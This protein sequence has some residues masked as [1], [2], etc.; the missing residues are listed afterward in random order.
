MSKSELNVATIDHDGIK[1]SL[2]EFFKT[3]NFGDFNYEGSAINTIMDLLTRNDT[4]YAFFANMVANESFLDTAQVR[5][6]V[7]SHSQK[8]SYTPKTTTATRIICDIEIV[9]SSV[10]NVEFSIIMPAGTTFYSSV[11]RQSYFFTNMVPYTMFLDEFSGSYKVSDVELYQGQRVVNRF[12]HTNAKKHIVLNPR[13]DSSTIQMNLIQ[14]VETQDILPYTEANSLDDLGK[15]ER[16]WFRGENTQGLLTFEFGR[17]VFGVEPPDNAVIELTYISTETEHA[18]NVSSLNPSSTI[19][20]FSNILVNVTSAGF[21]GSEIDD[22]ETIRFLAP[23]FYQMQDRA[24]ND[25]DYIPLLKR[26]FPFITSGISWGGEENDPKVWGTVFLSL[27]TQDGL[28]ITNG[29]KDQMIKYIKSR[30]VGSITPEIVDPDIF[31][32][33]LNIQFAYDSR[34][35]TST[36]S[37]LTSKIIDVV[38]KYNDDLLEFNSYYN[39]SELISQL[40]DVGGLESV[41]IF[42][43]ITKILNVFRFPNPIYI[44]NFG[45]VLKE[46]T[47]LIENFII[48][49]SASNHKIYDREGLI[50]SSYL[51][52]ERLIETEIGVIEYNTGKVE[53]TVNFIQDNNKLMMYVET[54]ENNYYVSQN[55]IVSINNIDTSLLN[56]VRR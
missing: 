24:L 48:D 32:I 52:N 38:N 45:N 16:V 11:N 4:Y 39:Q 55:K 54:V 6:N 8:L 34:Y 56:I 1:R 15:N 12:V 7:S 14:E 18:N 27:I 42:K 10:D 9:P 46:G 20:N 25:S 47:L 19:D 50:Y 33:D 5:A 26:Q 21:G 13:I 43:K 28:L 36:F 37:Q 41:Y 29:V 35:T 40:K 53:F 2:V 51:I 3:T 44:I 31:G 22:I 17:D 30:N 23:K 49:V